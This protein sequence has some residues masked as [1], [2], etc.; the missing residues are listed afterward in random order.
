VRNAVTALAVARIL[1]RAGSTSLDDQAIVVH[2]RR[3]LAGTSS[4]AWARG[5][6]YTSTARTIRRRAR[7]RRFL[8]RE[9][10]RPAHLS[11][12]WAVRDKAVDEVAG[13]LFPR[14]TKVFI[15]AAKQRGA[16][17]AEALAEMTGH[18]SADLEAVPEPGMAL[19]RALA[20]AQ[21]ED[22]VSSRARSTWWAISGGGG[23]RERLPQRVKPPGAACVHPAS[24]P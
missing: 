24:V 20:V 21:P 9:F 13:V 5:P 12:L 15:T 7:A 14:A 6:P 4:I 11:C 17:S 8:G 16:I 3:A 19:E 10:R 2:C 1:A 18:L 23:A 22:T